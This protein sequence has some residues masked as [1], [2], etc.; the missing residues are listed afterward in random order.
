M[1]RAKFL[2]LGIAGSGA[3]TLSDTLSTGHLPSLEA[4]GDAALLTA[5]GVIGVSSIRAVPERI[6]AV[7]GA[8]AAALGV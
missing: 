7:L 5:A 1:L 4:R 6:G 2:S 8:L 3:D